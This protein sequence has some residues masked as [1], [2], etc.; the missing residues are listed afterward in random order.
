MDKLLLLLVENMRE[1]LTHGE[2]ERER[3]MTKENRV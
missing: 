2:R 3:E 1:R